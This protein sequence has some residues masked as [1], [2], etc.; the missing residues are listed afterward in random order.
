MAVLQNQGRTA[1]ARADTDLPDVPTTWGDMRQH[2][3]WGAIYHG[4][5]LAGWSLGGALAYACAIG[6]KQAGAPTVLYP[7]RDAVD[8]TVGHFVA[9]I[10]P[11]EETQ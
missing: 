8:Y 2:I 5:V 7:M 4:F 6:L 11:A 9:L 1:L 3:F 10:R